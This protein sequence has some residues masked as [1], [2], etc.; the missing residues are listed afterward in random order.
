MRYT[1]EDVIV[2]KS[3]TIDEDGSYGGSFKDCEVKF[4]NGKAFNSYFDNCNI[5][6]TLD[7]L[8]SERGG[9]GNIFRLCKFGQPTSPA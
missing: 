4:V 3:V 6:I 7:D 1:Y 2:G 9:L 5:N 8:L